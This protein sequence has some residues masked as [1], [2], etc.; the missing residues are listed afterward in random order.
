MKLSNEQK[1]ETLFP[2]ALYETFTVLLQGKQ[3]RL[4]NLIIHL[5]IY[6]IISGVQV[7]KVV[8]TIITS[9]PLIEQRPNQVVRL[10]LNITASPTSAG[11]TGDDLWRAT[12]FVNSQP[13]GSGAR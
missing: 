2:L 11:I 4:P 6:V 8:S 3:F 1:P 9:A 7:V 10:E 5:P 13:D 12:V